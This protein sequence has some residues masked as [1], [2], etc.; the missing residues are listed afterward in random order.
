MSTRTITLPA[1]QWE[2]IL[3]VVRDHWDEGPPGEGW[4]GSRLSAASAALST[5]LA[6]PEPDGVTDEEL[7]AFFVEKGL[8]YATEGTYALASVTRNVHG[9]VLARAFRKALARWGRPTT[10]PVPVAERFE[11]SVFNSEYEEQAGG[12]APTYAE[13]L[14]YGQHYL[15]QYSQDGPHSLEI[16]RVEV[17]PHHALPVPGAEVPPMPV[18]GDAEGLAEV[19]WGRYAQPEPQGLPPRV[20][21]I[22]RLAEII[23]EVDGSHD[24]GAAA[25]AEAILSHPGSRWSPTIEPEGVGDEELLCIDDLRNAWNAQADAANSW[26][27]LGI[28]E[29]VW[30][31][32]QQ[33]LTRYAHP[34]IEPVPVAERLPGPEDCDGDGFCW[35]WNLQWERWMAGWQ[36]D[37]CTYWL[38]HHALPLPTPTS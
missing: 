36:D 18:P 7:G 6:Q 14:S 9:Q 25:L 19:F 20:G 34:A 21:H 10:Q 11:F 38:P 26:D 12:T 37:E 4:Q 1:D 27:E 13:A 15:S 29:I 33:A 16:R 3:E 23:R 17:L 35:F 5:A 8:L 31:A 24:K 2:A 30:F 32:Q 22:L 28:D